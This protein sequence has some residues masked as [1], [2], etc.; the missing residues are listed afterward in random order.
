[1]GIGVETSFKSLKLTTQNFYIWRVTRK[2]NV[3]GKNVEK[4]RGEA[5][6]NNMTQQRM[7]HQQKYDTCLALPKNMVGSGTGALV[8][9]YPDPEVHTCRS[10]SDPSP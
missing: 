7:A 6:I 8:F 1:M 9:E 3:A 4:R 2:Q 10:D 5:S